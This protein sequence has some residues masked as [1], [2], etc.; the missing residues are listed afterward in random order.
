MFASILDVNIA[1]NCIFL[2]G[3]S[4]GD[5]SVS[6]HIGIHVCGEEMSYGLFGTPGR[7]TSPPNEK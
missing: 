6:E 5:Q 7:S 3:V 1:D 4:L 2:L